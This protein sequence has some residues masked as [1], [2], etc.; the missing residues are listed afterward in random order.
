[1]MALIGIRADVVLDFDWPEEHVC[2]LWAAERRN[3]RLDLVTKIDDVEMLWTN[4]WFLCNGNCDG[5][6]SVEM[7]KT[8]WRDCVNDDA[9]CDCCC[10]WN[11]DDDLDDRC[12]FFDDNPDLCRSNEMILRHRIVH[13][14]SSDC[15]DHATIGHADLDAFGNLLF[16]WIMRMIG[17]HDDYYDGDCLI[18]CHCVWSVHSNPLWGY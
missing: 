15:F 11:D 17:H 13:D 18:R 14:L 2:C 10:C 12:V 9:Y 6:Q 7:M 8:D 1:M 16:A 3:S 5:V 4:C